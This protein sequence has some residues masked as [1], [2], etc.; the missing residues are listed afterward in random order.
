MVL[1]RDTMA[2]GWQS[3]GE[4]VLKLRWFILAG[5]A[6]IG[7]FVL[8]FKT[9]AQASSEI[10]AL[11]DTAALLRRDVTRLSVQDGVFD[12]N[13]LYVRLRQDSVLRWVDALATMRC[14][15]SNAHD[16]ALL[17]SAGLDCTRYAR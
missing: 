6:L 5:F 17:R 12:A 8:P 16:R 3:F 4:A 15:E 14:L 1:P 10:N 13:L 11:R 9:P 2:A 7:W